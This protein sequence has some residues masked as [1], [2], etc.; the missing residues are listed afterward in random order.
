MKNLQKILAKEF[1]WFLVALIFAFPLA[2]V[3]L[4]LLE[5]VVN[6]YDEFLTRINNN[7]VLLYFIF[8]VCLFI[9]IIL[10]RIISGAVKV[11][12]DPKDI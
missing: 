4:T 1:V 2:L 11:L 3:P 8:V 7:V 12:F 5:L 6:D 10:I 9:G